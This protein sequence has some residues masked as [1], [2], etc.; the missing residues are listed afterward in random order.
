MSPGLITNCSHIRAEENW[1][2]NKNFSSLSTVDFTLKPS[3][4][5][6][7]MNN[8][9]RIMEPAK[10]TFYLHVL[11]ATGSFILLPP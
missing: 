3:R 6:D 4:Y 10:Y 1:Y 9:Q 2:P 8:V 5:G 11:N 7:F